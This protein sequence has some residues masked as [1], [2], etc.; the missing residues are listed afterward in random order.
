MA[1]LLLVVAM[2]LSALAVAH[3]NECVDKCEYHLCSGKG[4][5]EIGKHTAHKAITGPICSRKT[6]EKI[7]Y[8]QMGDIAKTG[9]AHVLGK[10]ILP[11]SLWHPRGLMHRFRPD[12]F[13]LFEIPGPRG[14]KRHAI[15][16]VSLQKNQLAFLNGT[17]FGVPLQNYQMVDR[18]GL[19]VRSVQSRYVLDCV[20]FQTFVAPVMEN[21]KEKYA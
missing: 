19:A 16:H 7:D 2:L 4:V 21:T 6:E 5:V 10:Y 1:R 8:L 14:H 20:V 15:G 13:K 12:F 9:Q 17:C 18:K 3:G 11:I